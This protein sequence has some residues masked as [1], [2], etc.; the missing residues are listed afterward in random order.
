MGAARRATARK[1]PAAK[2]PRRGKSASRVPRGAKAARRGPAPR[3]TG[4][5]SGNAAGERLA[6]IAPVDE[7]REPPKFELGIDPAKIDEAVAAIR[8][9][10]SKLLR[11]GFADKIRIKYR[12]KPLGPDIPVAYF[13]AAEG[14]A[15][16]TAGILRVLLLNLGAKALLEVELISSAVEHHGKG[17]ERYLAGDVDGALAFF[18]KAVESDEYHAPSQRMLGTVLKVK[19]DR[20]RAR[21]HLARAADLDPDGEDGRKAKELLAGL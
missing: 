20:D 14:F 15:F 6:V 10:V 12:G 4:N 9:Q 5:A 3:G 19:G 1:K 8:A 16:F 17:L 2:S 11:R 7:R 18:E 13:L 21:V